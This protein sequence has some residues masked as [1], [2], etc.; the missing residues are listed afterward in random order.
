MKEERWSDF[1][2]F[3]VMADKYYGY[4]KADY[5]AYL[6]FKVL[7]SVM[8]N[9]SKGHD[10]TNYYHDGEPINLGVTKSIMSKAI[11]KMFKNK[12]DDSL[13]LVVRRLSLRNLRTR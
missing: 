10:P 11:D 12:W 1:D 2:K 7:K 9:C 4:I 13:H 6:D 3:V 8:E 5:P